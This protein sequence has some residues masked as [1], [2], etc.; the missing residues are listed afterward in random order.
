VTK[1]HKTAIVPYSAEQMYVLV[2]AVETYSQ[3][4]PWCKSAHLLSE[5]EGQVTACIVM[6]IAGLEKSFTTNNLLQPN[7]AIEMRLLEGPFSQ[8]HG[9]WKFQ[10]LGHEGCKISLD[11]QFEIANKLLR[12]SLGP[13]FS[14]IVSSLVDAF[15]KRANELYGKSKSYPR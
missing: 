4:L 14:K 11:M 9:F 6:S 2:N 15:V 1:I 12:M 3:F 8:L 7:Y 5:N 13:I 10:A